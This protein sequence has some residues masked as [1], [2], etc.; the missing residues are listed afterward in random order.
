MDLTVPKGMGGKEAASVLLKLDPKAKIVLSSGY[1]NH[2]IISDF[3][4]FGFVGA[5]AKPYRLDEISQI[6]EHVLQL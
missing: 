2:P 5:M 1:S 3:Q 6:I 4:Q